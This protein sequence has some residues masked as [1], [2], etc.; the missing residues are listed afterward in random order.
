MRN[1]FIL[2]I[3]LLFGQSL[4]AQNTVKVYGTIANPKGNAAY[5]KYYKD[6]L[7]FDEALAD[8]AVLD[9][10]GNF[11]MEFPWPKPYLAT[12][13]HGDEI[14]NMFLSPGDNLK[15]TLNTEMFDETLVY[16]GKGSIV[17]NYLAQK[18]LLFP[19]EDQ[20]LFNL[21]EAE[22]IRTVDESHA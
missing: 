15:L 19:G 4:L 12:F 10:D 9:A 6:Y 8:S 14:T 11:S 20:E 3:S 16:E 13:Y 1:Y 18:M 2:L 5:I 17:N 22:F 7:S 21:N